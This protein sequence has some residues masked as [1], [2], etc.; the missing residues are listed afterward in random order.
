MIGT[1]ETTRTL[2]TGAFGT[3]ALAKKKNSD[4]FYAIKSISKQNI[5]RSQMGEQVKKEISIMK[6]L[7]HPNIVRIIEVLMSTDYLYI[8]MDYVEGGELYTKIARGGRLQNDECKK[9]VR[10]L[11]SA[12]NYCH[13]RNVCHRDIKPQNILLDKNDNALLAD[14]GF[15]SIMEVDELK[16][17]MG[18]DAVLKRDDGVPS[19]MVFSSNNNDKTSRDMEAP[20]RMMK[21]MSTVCGTMAYMAPEIFNREKYFGDKADVWSLGVVIYVLLVGFMPFKESDTSKSRYVTPSHVHPEASDFVSAMLTLR[22]ETRLSARRLL[23][24]PW[25]N[26]STDS[27]GITK[28]YMNPIVE[29]EDDIRENIAYTEEVEEEEQQPWSCNFKSH[30]GY[31]DKSDE[32]IIQQVA[33]KMKES[34]WKVI[35]SNG[36]IRGSLLSPSGMAMV[37]VSISG[38]DI[39]VRNAKLTKDA[40]VKVM[41]ELDSLIETCLKEIKT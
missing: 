21:A 39:D 35:K 13:S 17:N 26:D 16:K 40:N 1:Y 32:F 8:V 2:G 19:T 3:V 34:G 24:H 38:R 22:P 31:S 27:S 29:E 5:L 6:D 28:G 7:D 4:T 33:S 23:I 15:A 20:S 9:Y 10:Q 11:C 37:S 12:L 18:T 14:F 25:I 30:I 41:Q 36:S